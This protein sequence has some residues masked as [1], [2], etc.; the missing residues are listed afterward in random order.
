[1]VKQKQPQ[2]LTTKEL[3]AEAQTYDIEGR[4]NMSKAELVVAIT[5]ARKLAGAPRAEKSRA[6]IGSKLTPERRRSMLIPP[7]GPPGPCG[8]CGSDMDWYTV[9]TDNS[10][11]MAQGVALCPHDGCVNGPA[12][13]AERMGWSTC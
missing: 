4:A 3:Y 2:S 10:P 9:L 7:L 12:K 8:V 11:A 5:N 6:K 13:T 1:M